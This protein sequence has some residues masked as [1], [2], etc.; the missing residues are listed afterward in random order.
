MGIMEVID[1]GIDNL[2][3][4][5]S[6]KE[7]VNLNLDDIDNLEKEMNDLSSSIQL[8]GET[9]GV[10][11][12]KNDSLFSNIEPKINIDEGFTDS[13]LGSATKDTLGNTKTW[14]GFTK[15]N[16]VPNVTPSSSKKMSENEKKLISNYSHFTMDSEFDEVEDEYE[17]ALDDKR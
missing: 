15:I 6:K 13:N 17:T 4:I 11:E 12:V 3:P 14:D 5:S 2:E 8:G 7:E 9:S 16:E 10:E 1:I